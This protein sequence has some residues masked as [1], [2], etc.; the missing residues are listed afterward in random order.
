MVL[1]RSS[2]SWSHQL[3]IDSSTRADWHPFAPNG[4]PGILIRRLDVFFPTSLR[5]PFLRPPK[6][7]EPATR[8]PIGI[9]AT[10]VLLHDSTCRLTAMADGWWRC[11]QWSQLKKLPLQYVRL[12]VLS[13]SWAIFSACFSTW[14]TR[15]VR[16]SHD[17]LLPR[18]YSPRAPAL[19]AAI[20]STWMAGF[21]VGSPPDFSD[22]GRWRPLQYRHAFSFAL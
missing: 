16:R 4:W 21:L 11:P 15:K 20:L 7:E 2:L 1:L 13:H 12:I 14:P 18:I 3:R 17:G 19:L 9:I 8:R 5:L 22:I 10:L 6:N